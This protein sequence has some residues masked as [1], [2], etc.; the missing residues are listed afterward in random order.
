MLF[1]DIQVKL[2][3]CSIYRMST[4]ETSQFVP[5][6]HTYCESYQLYIYFKSNNTQ[7]MICHI[8]TTNVHDGL[9]EHS[10]IDFIYEYLKKTHTIII[11]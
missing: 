4:C 5:V 9:R 1:G 3:I 8:I 11:M 6:H 7:N 10:E 2:L